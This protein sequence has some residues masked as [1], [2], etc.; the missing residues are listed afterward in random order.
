[1][2]AVP[3]IGRPLDR[4]D[5][6]LKVTGAALYAYEVTAS[7][8]HA[9]GFIV[10]ATIAKGR[11]AAIDTRPAERAPGVLL[12][13][14]HRNAPRQSPLG[15]PRVPNRFA[16]ARPFLS[17]DR[18]R[19][20]GQPVAF[21]V[22]ET[23]EAARH[24]AT[25]VEVDYA[26]EPQR[27]DLG[28]NLDTA[29]KPEGIT[30]SGR[31]PTDSAL[32]DFEA[33]FAVGPVTVE[34]VYWTSYQ[35]HA[36]MEPHAALAEWNGGKLTVF[37]PTQTVADTRAAV[38]AT[39]EMPLENVRIV[40]PYVG[41]GFGGKLGVR[42]ETILAALAARELRR[43]VKAAQT[44]QQTFH[45][46]GHRPAS[47]QVVKL[48]AMR[49]GRLT[50][51]SHDVVGQSTPSDEFAEQNAMPT[52]SLYAAPNRS[53]RHR[54]VNLDMQGG[55][56]VRAPGEAPGLLVLETA[57]DELAHELGV[58]PVELRIRNEPEIDPERKVPFSSR[59][60]VRCLRE[61]AERFGWADRPATPGSRRD[62]RW[63]V[64][65]GVAAG[66][67][68]NYIAKAEASVS[69]DREGVVTVRTDMTDIGTG[70]YTI[71]TQIAADE[72]GLPPDHVVVQLGDSR[73]P[74]SPGSG[75]SW[76]AASAGS[77]VKDACAKL[78]SKIL[79]AARSTL[80]SPLSGAN[81]SDA[82]IRDGIVTCGGR[83]AP[84]ASIASVIAADG[85]EARGQVAGM[86]DN[87]AYKAF[88]QHGFGAHFAEVGVDAD[89]GEIRLRRMLGA[90]AVGKVLNPKTARSQ[91]IGGMIWGVSQALHEDAVIDPR[92]GQFVNHDLA[93][94]HVPVHADVPDVDAFFVPEEDDKGNALGIKGI[95]ELGIC[96]SG[97]AV[98][99]AVFN[100]T[101]V[102]ARSFPITLD[103]LLPGLPA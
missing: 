47:R 17:D 35:V 62:G 54:L 88:S 99:N 7:R 94:Y 93:E 53:T 40:S 75:G 2:T 86:A 64:G 50:G 14:T 92:F 12:V 15:P 80:G 90:F 31:T 91:M 79:A 45:N 46:V 56:P 100:A 26:A 8:A 101:G 61:G 98:G 19:F 43:P 52:R 81:D 38:A 97:A 85:L 73:F 9:Y 48:A 36:A 18:V 84:L 41:G 68:S 37:T 67:R 11:I 5:G 77:A 76:G 23:F 32:G 96:G 78:R 39:L 63:L 49:D 29:Y 59:N 10:P 65:Y 4:I 21:V 25:L 27:T 102:R 83:S 58:D 44:R 103:D 51:I 55:E 72:L 13:L 95:G 22:A 1:M 24:A 60:L 3:F 71:L 16:R 20:W 89:T 33:A 57:M 70:T 34:K 28:A 6:R 69:L 30:A 74:R 42:A 87:P 82:W 66:I